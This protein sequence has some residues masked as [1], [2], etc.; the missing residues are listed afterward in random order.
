MEDYESKEPD[1]QILAGFRKMAA[2]LVESFRTQR[3]VVQTLLGPV[4]NQAS[5]VFREG[6]LRDFLRRALPRAVEVSTGYVCGFEKVPNSG[7]IDILVWDSANHAPVYRTDS[8][9]IVP[10]ESV[11]L[12]VSV[13]TLATP[14][15]LTIALK[16]VLTLAELD[17]AYRAK[18]HPLLPPIG[19]YV[20]AYD[21]AA[22]PGAIL[23][24]LSRTMVNRFATD[25]RMA[26]SIVQVLRQRDPFNP[27]KDHAWQAARILPQ[28]LVSLDKEN[29]FAFFGG[30]WGPGHDVLDTPEGIKRLPYMYPTRSTITSFFEKFVYRVLSDVYTYLNTRGRAL[31]AAW[32]DFDPIRSWR[33]GD[34]DEIE[35]RHGVPMLDPM[36]LPP[37]LLPSSYGAA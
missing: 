7:Q 19:K 18:L 9:V 15:E 35:E 32:G 33:V 30:G 14:T 34:A 4:Q 29:G 1:A 20:V 17:L 36:I 21:G 5:G 27:S 28:M 2:S 6:L 16:N 24:A 13:K 12:V 22:N 10:P 11:V 31:P 3:D 26:E 25:A 23:N 37:S 8:F